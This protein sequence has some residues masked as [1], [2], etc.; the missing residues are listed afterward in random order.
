[1]DGFL[2]LREVC[3]EYT[4]DELRQEVDLGESLWKLRQQE[5]ATPGQ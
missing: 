2:K 5:L 3:F 4:M 1:L